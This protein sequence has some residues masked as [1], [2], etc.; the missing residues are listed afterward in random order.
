[1][2]RVAVLNVALEEGFTDDAVVVAVDG[3][4]V[5]DRTGVRTRTQI[6]LAESFEVEVDEGRSVVD[7]QVPAR[8]AHGR[9]EVPVA[10]TTFVG[11]SLQ[12]GDVVFRS[13]GE[14]FGYL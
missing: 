13:S 5:F 8:D 3:R 11:V 12:G 2:R 7:V 4:T 9:L 14:P 10:A 6:G 1:V